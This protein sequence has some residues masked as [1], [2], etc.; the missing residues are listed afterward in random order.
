MCGGDKRG[1]AGALAG[2]CL[3]QWIWCWQPGAASC[4]TGWPRARRPPRGLSGCTQTQP[5]TLERADPQINPERDAVVRA[6][7]HKSSFP[8]RSACLLSRPD[9]ATL[10]PR[11]ATKEMGGA[12]PPGA[13]HSAPCRA[14]AWRGWRATD[15]LRSEHRGTLIT[16]QRFATP[17][18]YAASAA[19]SAIRG[20]ITQF[21]RQLP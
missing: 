12:E 1:D 6:A 17:G 2:G 16:S 19:T 14:R 4:R 13:T 21:K 11:S 20:I 9:L 8:V 18:I 3:G 7:G 10:E 15:L 5:A